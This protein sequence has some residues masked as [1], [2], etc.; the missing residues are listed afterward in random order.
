LPTDRS[1]QLTYNLKLRHI[2]LLEFLS[3]KLKVSRSALLRTIIDEWW[4]RHD[5]NPA[6]HRPP[7]AEQDRKSQGRD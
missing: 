4:A 6:N 7:I 1:I 3:G 2:E 5:L